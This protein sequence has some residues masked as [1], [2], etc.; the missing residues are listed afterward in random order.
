MKESE[1]Y[2][3]YIK[4]YLSIQK[5][6]LENGF[7]VWRPSSGHNVELLHIVT[8]SPGKGTGREL[9][10]GMLTKLK[11]NP[12]YAT[13]SGFTRTCNERAKDFYLAMGFELSVVKG[14]YDDGEAVLFSQRFNTLLEIHNV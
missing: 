9:I 13:V 14:V 4:P 11:E 1:V 7:I 10:K 5:Y 3:R 8:F 6:D 2:E 12:P